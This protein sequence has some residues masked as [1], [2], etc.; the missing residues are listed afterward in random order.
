MLRYINISAVVANTI[1]CVNRLYG[2]TTQKLQVV[3]QPKQVRSPRS[4][5][6]AYVHRQNPQLPHSSDSFLSDM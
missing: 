1:P 3:P 6:A 5:Q 2:L 4:L